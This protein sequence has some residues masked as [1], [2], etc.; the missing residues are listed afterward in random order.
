MLVEAQ[1]NTMK[2]K[3][4]NTTALVTLFL[5]FLA[6]YATAGEGG[7]AAGSESIALVPLLTASLIFLAVMALVFGISLALTAKKFFVQTD[8]KVE[9][10]TEAL[11]HAHCGACGFAGCEQYA[12]AVLNDPGVPPNLCT[13]GGQQC[14]NLVAELTGKIPQAREPQYA[15]IMCQGSHDKAPKKFSYEGFKDCRAAVL[16]GGGDKACP[17]GC[18]GYGTCVRVCP[19]GA[20]SMGP[21]GLPVV[22]EKK[23]TGC[24]KCAAA[25][26]KKVIEILPASAKIFVACH[27][28]DKGAVTRKYCTVG[29]IGC[30][31][32]VKVCP[33]SPVKAP[34]VESNLS[35]IDNALCT[36]CGECVKNCPTKAIVDISGKTTIAPV[37]EQAT[38]SA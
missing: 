22:N 25:C 6:Q 24:K 27:S 4:D 30:G 31:K 38:V 19:F 23:C 7:G 32:C 36:A 9:Q 2:K 29:C 28:K 20:L 11:A 3:I 5:C 37:V 14:T 33:V 34:K 10:I 18:L 15:R 16:T 8:P 13:P 1:R 26:P 21:N 12:Q 17:Y 35:R